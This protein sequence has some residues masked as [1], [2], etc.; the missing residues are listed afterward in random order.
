[1][2]LQKTLITIQITSDTICPWCIIGYEKLRTAMEKSGNNYDFKVYFRP[3]F[4]SRD[5]P[6]SG[7]NFK[8]YFAKKGMILDLNKYKQMYS[9][10]QMIGETLENKVQFAGPTDDSKCYNTA[11][12]HRLSEWCLKKYGA[13]KQVAL[14]TKILRK[15][16]EQSLDISSIEVLAETASEV[17]LDKN[18][19]K[20]FLEDQNAQPTKQEIFKLAD[21]VYQQTGG[22]G[23]PF[24][25]FNGVTAVSGGQDPEV[26]MN[27]FETIQKKSSLQ[28]KEH[29]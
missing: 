27:I 11:N 4:L 1:M 9:R 12:S 20:Q 13:E 18:E 6:E 29:L 21:E 3:F 17:G 24:F 28:I 22:N 14:Y 23:V 19:V 7:L 16:F 10:I 15:N 26:F 5:T 8:D 2:S 25:V